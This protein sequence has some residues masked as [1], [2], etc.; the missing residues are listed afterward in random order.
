V[1]SAIGPITIRRWHGRC[2]ACIE[3]GFAADGVIGLTGWLTLRARRMACK[4]GLHDPFRK[5]EELL[6]ELAGWSVDAETL[7]R[8]THA[9]AAE[10]TRCRAAR[11]GLPE[12]FASAIGEA[13]ADAE[14]H[15]DAGKVNTP[16]GWR[17]VKVAA[18][19][20]RT[21]GPAATSEDYEQRELPAP[22]VRSVIA[23]VEDVGAFAPR[24]QAE[25]TRLGLTDPTRLSVLGDG[26]EWIWN[27]SA[28]LFAGAAEVLDVFHALEHLAAA[29]R[30]AFA[31]EPGFADWLSAARRRVVGDG[32]CG[33]CTTWT[34][35]LPDPIAERLAAAAGPTLNYFA[36]HRDRLG[37]AVRLER[38]QVIGSGLVEGT[39]KE[40]VNLRL[41]RTGARWL[42]QRVGPF[43]E[44]LALSDTVEWDQH[45]KSL[46]A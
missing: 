8:H 2:R 26:A 32:Y 20:V 14:V 36:G 33:V 21:R 15:I 3:V 24:C 23:A 29:G 25:A 6:Q 10:A 46:A 5:A 44:F 1:L 12:A 41:K 28:S 40:R 34:Q 35:P 4:A 13:D 16:E 17:D 38:G 7:R 43:V 42:A 39:I 45:W 31:T 18:F 27:L 19:A 22:T 11:T 9:E 37:Y 30:M